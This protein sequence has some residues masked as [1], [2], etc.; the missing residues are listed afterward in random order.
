M[1]LPYA[2]PG[3]V[4]FKN[5]EVD[6]LDECF[7]KLF[8]ACF[9]EEASALSEASFETRK[10][11]IAEMIR[12]AIAEGELP[13]RIDRQTFTAWLITHDLPEADIELKDAIDLTDQSIAG[14]TSYLARLEAQE[15]GNSR[16]YEGTKAILLS[17]LK[18]G[19]LKCFVHLDG[20]PIEKHYELSP[21]YWD[22][23]FADTS[24]ASGATVFQ[25]GSWPHFKFAKRPLWVRKGDCDRLIAEIKPTRPQIDAQVQA[26]DKLIALRKKGPPTKN[27]E[28]YEDQFIREIPG[29]T[30]SAFKRAWSAAAAAAPRDDWSKPGP[31]LQEKKRS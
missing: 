14:I 30:A 13:V 7:S 2:D 29:L 11:A 25:N 27:K 18:A 5:R 23:M 16:A 19:E 24:L 31:R 6:S 12:N 10:A 17:R 21:D 3:P 15:I 9:P 26:R 20:D 28:G 22:A 8:F 1:K 4:Y